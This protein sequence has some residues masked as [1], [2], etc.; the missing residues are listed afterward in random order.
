M[1]TG[2]LWAVTEEKPEQCRIYDHF[3]GWK[4]NLMELL[5]RWCTVYTYLLD[6]YVGLWFF[7]VV[8]YDS[9]ILLTIKNNVEFMPIFM[10]GSWT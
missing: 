9:P 10:A 1:N 6:Q 2:I 8:G 3:Q 5:K 4:L 7:N